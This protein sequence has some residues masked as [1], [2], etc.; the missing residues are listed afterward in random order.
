MNSIVILFLIVVFPITGLSQVNWELKKDKE[1]IKVYTKSTADSDV[2]AVKVICT[3]QAKLSQLAA[4]LLDTKAHE[5]WVYNT[6]TSFLVKQ[7]SPFQQVYYSEID[8]PWPLA[9]R[10]VV[11]NMKI[12]QHPIT[13]VMQVDIVNASDH[14]PAQKGTVRVPASAVNWKVTPLGNNQLGVEYVGL[15]DP[16]G[17]VP[18]WVVNAFSTK[19]PF[20]TFKKLRELVGSPIYAKAQYDF[21]S[22]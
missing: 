9:N 20:E 8:L 18:A 13:K 7:I 6:K 12:I 21:I 10:E 14:V 3:L 4:L 19:G 16:G 15:A 2:K 1:G 22:E 11:V 17:S 5:Q